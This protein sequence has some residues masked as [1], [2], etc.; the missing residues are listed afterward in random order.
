MLRNGIEVEAE[1]V[2][3][4]EIDLSS[5]DSTSIERGWECIYMYV[6]PDGVKYTGGVGSFSQKRYAVE[7]LGEKVRIV[8]D[9]TDGSSTYGTLAG[10]AYYWQ[11]YHQIDLILA[12]VFIG[13]LCMAAYLFF[14]RVVYRNRLDKKILEHAS[15]IFAS[16]CV[17]EGEVTKVLKWLVC[18]VKVRY[19]DESGVTREKWARSWFTHKEAKFLRQ[20]KTINIIPYKNTYGILEEMQVAK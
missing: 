17:R 15:G 10:I 20:K 12:C 7:H 5:A 2:D 18:Y 4:M 19:Q 9:P 14:Y 16:D 1:I 3:I 13:L 11:K 8:I 6:A